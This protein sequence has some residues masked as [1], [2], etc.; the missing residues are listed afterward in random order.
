MSAFTDGYFTVADGLKLH[1]RNYPGPAGHAP[2]LCLPGLTRN[3]RDFAD[4]AAAMAGQRQVIVLEFRGRGESEHDLQGDR[5]KPVTYVQDLLQLLD[6]L[7]IGKAV[8]V[9]TSL[10]GIVT[11]LTAVIAGH[12]IAAAVL[13]DVGPELEEAGLERIRGY[14]GK[15]SRFA[16][17]QQA[18]AAIAAFNED[19]PASYSPEDWDGMARRLCREEAD[20]TICFDYDMAIAEPF[21]RDGPSEQVDM[22][23]LFDALAVHP[24]LVVRG[25]LS[26]L[27]SASALERMHARAPNMQSVTVP[28][29]GHAP[30]LVEP[31]AIAAIRA[32]LATVD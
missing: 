8:F 4:F 14:V 29:V 19:I 15:Q 31:E 32:F 17:W 9:G 1:F 6:H 7:G 2:L 23:P 18:A 25:G 24:L 26:D 21:N 22:W 13:N 12:R 27:F 3:V 16:T 30:D 11:M 5:Y 20:G 28:G 10:G